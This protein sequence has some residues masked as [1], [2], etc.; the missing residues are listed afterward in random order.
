MV[1]S[2]LISWQ[3]WRQPFS[4]FISWQ[5]PRK[6]SKVVTL[7]SRLRHIGER[8][9]DGVCLLLKSVSQITPSASRG[10]RYLKPAT[11]QWL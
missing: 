9:C 10:P 6:L 7:R 2:L 1:N 11:T 4:C 8:H 3:R 5:R